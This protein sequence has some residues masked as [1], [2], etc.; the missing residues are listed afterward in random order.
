MNV[1]SVLMIAAIMPIAS[2]QKVL[3]LVDVKVVTEVMGFD[4]MTLMNAQMDNT[5][6][7]PTPNAWIPMAHLHVS[8]TKASPVTDYLA[9]ILMSAKV[10]TTVLL[11]LR[12]RI[13]LVDLIVNV[14]MVLLDPGKF[15]WMW[16]NVLTEHTH[17][18]T[19]HHVQIFLV[20]S[21]VTVIMVSLVTG[22][23]VRTLMNVLPTV[24]IVTRM[25]N[26]PIVLDHL[27][28]HV[29]SDLPVMELHVLTSMNVWINPAATMPT[30]QIILVVSAVDAKRDIP[31]KVITVSIQMNVTLAVTI[32]RLM[33]IATTPMV[34]LNANV[35][36]D[37]K[38]MA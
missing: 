15:V 16:M 12:V 2:I 38:E 17:A 30:A 25:P 3:L 23:N 33:L 14:S 34:P 4:V 29:E 22:Q 7:I 11:L 8:A 24:I 35:L 26:V 32:V 5:L 20:V 1:K 10:D 36:M 31:V 27:H 37:L 19:T 18:M 6:V 13:L 21:I 9:R 28:A